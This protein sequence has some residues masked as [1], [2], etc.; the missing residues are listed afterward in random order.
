MSAVDIDQLEHSEDEGTTFPLEAQQLGDGDES[1]AVENTSFSVDELTVKLR[2]SLTLDDQPNV[3]PFAAEAAETDSRPRSADNAAEVHPADD[4]S[5]FFDCENKSFDGKAVVEPAQDIADHILHSQSEVDEPEVATVSETDERRDSDSV[6]VDEKM[7]D[8]VDLPR[9]P[10]IAITRGNYNINWDELDENSDPFSLKKAVSHSPPK[11]PVVPACVGAGDGHPVAEID[12]F[13]P[14]RRLSN[15][16][17]DTDA[18]SASSPV[19]QNR[20]CSINNNL[21]E[22]VIETVVSSL[23]D[24]VAPSDG[25]DDVSIASETKTPSP[26]VNMSNNKQ[27]EVSESEATPECLN[28]V[29]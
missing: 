13:K 12:P 19:K 6:K 16:Q 4:S 27:P 25:T 21:P 11:S 20:R 22:P 28:T 26:C 24:S 9:S 5:T 7:A 10:P 2:K 1:A 15:S 14:H 8:N 23:A 18:A 17:P 29:E 3:E